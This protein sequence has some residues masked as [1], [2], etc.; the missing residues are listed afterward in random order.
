VSR[1]VLLDVDT[2]YDDALALLTAL[3][4]PE[5][6][7]LGVTC[8]AGNQ[9]LPQVVDNTLRL[10]DYVGAATPVAAGADR[11]LVEVR[12]DPPALHGRDGMA[13]LSLPRALRTVEPVH[14]VEFMRDVLMDAAKPVSLICLAPLTNLALLL[15]MYPKIATRIADVT[16]MGGTL[17]VHGNTS[18]L[19]E[20]NIRTDPEAAAIVFESG[21]VVRLYPLDVFRAIQFTLAEAEWLAARDAPAANAA[22]RILRFVCKFFDRD[23]ALVGDAGTVAALI[24]PA[25]CTVERYPVTVA[26]GAGVARGMTVLDRRTPGQR[27][28]GTDWWPVSASEIEVITAVDAERYRALLSRAWVKSD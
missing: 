1:P 3:G 14:A 20:F 21:L 13:E 2:G 9:D 18:P 22:G 26:L 7:V 5:L 23:A 25:G 28:R 8:V 27:T 4:S 6:S 16:I 10:L 11:A 12:H 24:D 19:A 17:A 15:R